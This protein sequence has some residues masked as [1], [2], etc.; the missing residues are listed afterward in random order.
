MDFRGQVWKRERKND[1]FWSEIGSRLGEPRNTH[2]PTKNSQEY[3]PPP[4]ESYQ[5]LTFA[6]SPA[7][8]VIF[9]V[10]VVCSAPKAIVNIS[11][12]CAAFVFR[13]LVIK[14]KLTA[15]AI[16]SSLGTRYV[17]LA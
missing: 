13:V 8:S 15:I 12:T 3:P 10:L 5:S 11:M 14:W 9:I 17:F 2:T 1:V 16:K 4:P 7:F 6:V